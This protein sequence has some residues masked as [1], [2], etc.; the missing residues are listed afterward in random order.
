MLRVLI[1]FGTRPEA[2][3]LAPVVQE[4]RRY[5]RQLQS[6]ACV[7]G[8]HR[9]MLDQTLNLF[10]IQPEIDLNLMQTNQNLA[11]FAA[12]TLKALAGVLARVRPDVV[13]VQGDTTSAMAAA[14]AAFYAKVPV[15][16]IE[17]GLRT[18]ARYCPFPEEINRHVL[19]ILATHHFAPTET[20]RQAL[21]Q[22]GVRDQDIYVTGNTAIDALLWVLQ[23]PPSAGTRSLFSKLNLPLPGDLEPSPKSLNPWRVVLVTVHRRESFGAALENI[24]RALR[25]IV[26]THPDVR[27]VFPVHLNPNVQNPVR[28][29]LSGTDR[30]ALIKPQPYDTF[31][32]LMK[33]AHILISDSGGIQEEAPSL[34]K[35]VLVLREKTERKEAVECGIVRVV[36][37]EASRIVEETRRLLEDSDRSPKWGQAVHIYGDGLASQRIAQ[38]LLPGASRPTTRI[39]SALG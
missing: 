18:G 16:H 8:Q 7:T 22:E 12:R 38:A 30:I 17:A 10:G 9:Q 1:I 23:R 36:G 13:L 33:C 3:K 39:S 35:P 24:C 11:A 32:Y 6:V 28:R 2:I 4:L 14:W 31:V 26:E 34:G 29:L 27:I 21:L 20:A 25:E 19:G 37:T 15:G 5:P